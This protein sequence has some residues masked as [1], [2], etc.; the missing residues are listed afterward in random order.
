MPAIWRT[1]VAVIGRTV[2]EAGRNTVCTSGRHGLV[3]AGD[4]HFVVEV[5]AVAQAADQDGGAALLRGSDGEIVV[6]GRL[7]RAAGLRGDR[8]EHLLNHL[9]ALLRRKQRLFA[10]VD[11]DGHDQPVAEADGMPD[12]VQMAV[13]DGVE[14]AGIERD[15]GHKTVLP[16]PGRRRKPDRFPPGANPLIWSATEPLRRVGASSAAGFVSSGRRRNKMTA[17][18]KPFSAWRGRRNPETAA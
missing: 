13:G 18:T 4:L 5:G 3:H 17:R 1:S 14:G 2:G 7:E 12:H 8:A 10:G 11:P 9:E 16:R 6:G 15:T